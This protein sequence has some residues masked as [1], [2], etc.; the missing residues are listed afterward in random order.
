[1]P[2]RRNART[3]CGSRRS[4]PRRQRRLRPH[5]RQ[6]P[7][8]AA[9]RAGQFFIWRFAGYNGWWKANPFS[10]SAAPG[11]N[12]LRP[13]PRPSA[14]PVPGCATYR[15]GRGASPRAVR[16]VHQH[17]QD[18]RRHGAD[19]RR[20]PG[21]TPI[22]SLLEE[23]SGPIAVLY[24]VQSPA[25]AVLLAEMEQLRADEGCT[26]PRP[27]R[28]CR[29][30]RPAEHP[31]RPVPRAARPGH[32]AGTRTSAGPHQAMTDAVLKSLRQLKVPPLQI[33]AERFALAS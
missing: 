5:D 22:R 7:A 4:C 9:A 25:D 3:S 33:H 17:P 31:V 19:R 18:P 10:L 27:R 32:P 14:K 2:L 29:R 24:R 13:P 16:R 1:M 6:G 20:G 26:G 15:S 28:P 11:H 8:T 21:V 30:G 23:L 12:A